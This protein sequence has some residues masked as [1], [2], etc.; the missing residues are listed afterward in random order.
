MLLLLPVTINIKGGVIFTDGDKNGT[1]IN[2]GH[3]SDAIYISSP[4][5]PPEVNIDANKATIVTWDNV[6]Y[7]NFPM[8]YVGGGYD[9][10]HLK[11]Y[12]G[13]ST[14]IFWTSDAG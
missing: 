4:G 14:R 11:N 3:G 13:S 7:N 5:N 9:N 2:D 6:A 8:R 12:P 1:E 10:R